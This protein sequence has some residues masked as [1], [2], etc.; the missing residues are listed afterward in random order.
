MRITFRTVSVALSTAILAAGIS[1]CSEVELVEN[2]DTGISD[3]T[4]EQNIIADTPKTARAMFIPGQGVIKFSEDMAEQVEQTIAAGKIATKAAGL[5]NIEEND[6]TSINL[7]NAFG[8]FFIFSCIV[9]ML[10]CGKSDSN[11]INSYSSFVETCIIEHIV[12]QQ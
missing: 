11:T 4:I 8:H 3:A 10:S 6:V 7:M 1:S 2:T 9:L 12:F 5:G